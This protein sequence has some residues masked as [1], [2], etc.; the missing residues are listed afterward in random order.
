M[1]KSPAW[2][3]KTEKQKRTF[4]S[5]LSQTIY[6]SMTF[7]IGDAITAGQRGQRIRTAAV[8]S[9]VQR[10]TARLLGIEGQVPCGSSPEESSKLSGECV[11]GAGNSAA[12]MI[13]KVIAVEEEKFAATIDQG[14]RII[15][16]YMDELKA[17]R[18]QNA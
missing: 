2:N 15:N 7:M 9:D 13:G 11:S 8:S 18:K 16:S 1:A 10:D 4:P 14:M 17:D 3:T 6:S 5:V 12:M